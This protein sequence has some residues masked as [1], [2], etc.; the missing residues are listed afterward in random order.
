MRA[1]KLTGWVLV[2]LL[3]V[4]GGG[5][6]SAIAHEPTV[7]PAGVVTEWQAHADPSYP[8]DITSGPDGNLWFVSQ[9]PEFVGRITPDGTITHFT[10]G[11]T[12]GSDLG[13]ITKGP[14][15]ALWFTGKADPG[16][17][18]RITTDGVVTEFTA[19]LTPNMAPSD[20]AEGSDGA[21]WFTESANPG[22]IGRIT[23]DGVVTEHSAGMTSGL[24]PWLITAGPD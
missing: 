24:A 14:D 18:G 12:P 13:S 10:A 9:S 2:S 11:I 20:I 4:L 16:R 22:A 7:T 23:T 6:A 17:I 19:G 5:T 21:L 1:R 8:V 15:G 3:A